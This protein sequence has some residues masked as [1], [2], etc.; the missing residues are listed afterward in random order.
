MQHVSADGKYCTVT[1]GNESTCASV[2]SLTVIENVLSDKR[3][4]DKLSQ[5][6]TKR[7]KL[8]SK[9]QKQTPNTTRSANRIKC[10]QIIDLHNNALQKEN[11]EKEKQKTEKDN[12]A[13]KDLL[14][15]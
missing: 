14:T 1:T 12:A 11:N 2:L 8:S 15:E 6:E 5:I 4:N 7:R 9:K 13:M 10:M 3:K